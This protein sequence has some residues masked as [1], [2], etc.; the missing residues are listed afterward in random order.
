MKFNSTILLLSL[1]LALA[2]IITGCPSPGPTTF[3]SPTPVLPVEDITKPGS[4]NGT[5]NVLELSVLDTP[6]GATITL[7]PEIDGVPAA[8]ASQ[9]TTSI[10]RGGYQFA[11]V[12]KGVYTIHAELPS[13]NTAGA[14]LVGD[15]HGV[16]V[17]G[18]IPTLLANIIIGVTADVV[19]L[20][21]IVTGP[22]TTPSGT[23]TGPIADA[24]V[25]LMVVAYSVAH[26]LQP[27]NI[28]PIQTSIH[29]TTDASGRYTI[30]VPKNAVKYVL[31]AA[32]TVGN[33][34]LTDILLP[35][36]LNT[37][38]I[39]LTAAGAITFPQIDTI[40]YVSTTFEAPTTRARQDAYY[41]RMALTANAATSRLGRAATRS[42]T[43]AT[44]RVAPTSLVENDLFNWYDS[45]WIG[46]DGLIHPI[47]SPGIQGFN[48]YR[49][50]SATQAPLW[51]GA[52][53]NRY[54]WGFV[55]NDPA[56]QPL[57]QYQYYVAA[58]AENNQLGKLSP[59]VIMSALPPIEV[60]T[61][62]GATMSRDGGKLS[63]KPVP[64]AKSYV[65]Q[66]YLSRPTYGYLNPVQEDRSDSVPSTIT[67]P[68]GATVIEV[69]LRI[70]SF[71]DR[72][73]LPAD[74]WW[75]VSAGDQK[76]FDNSY[77]ASYAQY[78]KIT[79][80]E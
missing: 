61:A 33:S 9:T 3:E 76:N 64:G 38:D 67:I 56:L 25:S 29:A 77:A 55:D 34:P 54:D 21:G 58:Y 19:T 70:A 65:V 50:T 60:I 46:T 39:I 24:R 4:I 69:P 48:V 36:A 72:Y 8:T 14:T 11:A 2:V 6:A 75:S 62:D 10:I 27:S 17:R 57:T 71:S 44:T 52:N 73:T 5:I 13:L 47:L 63:W 74:F 59:P 68:V 41:S 78:R 16:V 35:D 20:T 12:P 32:A 7:F 66:I 43:R 37:V 30:T 40:D 80:T 22:V 51:I 26:I 49:N 28:D 18:N 31:N 45:H 23:I 15:I 53:T 1:L 79:V 42:A